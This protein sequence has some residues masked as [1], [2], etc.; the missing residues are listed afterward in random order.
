[1]DS[2]IGKKLDGRYEITELI[3]VGGMA[4][5]YKAQDVMENRPVAVKILKPEFSKDEEFLRRFRNESKAIAVLSHPNIVKIY[6]VGFTDEIQFIVMEYIDGITLKEFIEQQGV[7]KWKDALHFITQ[8]LRALQHAHDKG[9]VHRDIKPQNIM[10][11]SDGTIKVMDFGIARFSRIDGKTMSD[12]TIGSVHYI[13][14]EQAQGLMTDER[15]D[16]YS[17]GIMLYEMLTGRKPFDGD[18]AVAVAVKH[19]QEKAINPREIM[20]SIPEALEEIVIHAMEKKPAD[21]YQSAAEMI[22]D[23]DTFKLNQSV[24]FGYKEGSVPVAGNAAMFPMNNA[25][26]KP[27]PAPAPVVFDDYDDDD[28]YDDGYDDRFNNNYDDD[29][30]DDEYDEDD[31]DEYE[32]EEPKR[33]YVVPILLAVTVAV[34]ICAACIIGWTVIK[35]FVGQDGQGIHTST[36]T[37]PNFIGKN[38]VQVQQDWGQTLQF[39]LQNEYNNDY[40]E[41]T[42]FW[43]SQSAG[44]TVKEGF[45]ITLKVSKGKHMATVPDVTG[46]ESEVAQSTLK[47]ADFNIVL[48]RKYDENVAEGMVISTEPAAGAE[49]PVG[50]TVTVYVSNGPLDTQVKVPNLVGLTKE[51]AVA[52]LKEAKLVPIVEE[53]AH[54][55]DKGKVVDQSY[56]PD[57][58]VEKGTEVTIMVSTGE[59]DPEKLQIKVELPSGLH[60]SY[61][62]EVYRNGNVAY[63]QPISNGE[64]VGSFV[65]IEVEGKKTETLTVT[66]RNDESG[67]SVNYCVYNI[68]YEKKVATL[69]GSF[70]KDG[71]LA[72]TP[73]TT[74]ESS[75]SSQ[76]ETSSSEAETTAPPETTP[77][78]ETTTPEPDTTTETNTDTEAPVDP[79]S[80]AE[81]F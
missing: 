46:T 59:T 33:S 44:K 62:I 24:V 61:S 76:A 10:L 48:R 73:T 15:S 18:K 2:N 45:T 8:I 69:N 63:T 74:A 14:P 52:T 81:L 37:I 55:G 23:I 40:D 51:K 38:I 79:S 42:I 9:I 21:R 70:N 27:Q 72:I 53:V 36:V 7:L 22:R 41:G 60:G 31:E 56:D 78:P 4:D 80:M 49:Y 3:G 32:Y 67:K 71:L 54:D 43:Q 66:I 57:T 47:A 77:E 26:K 65:N 30:D 35:S 5:V 50:G 25:P 11:F 19:M 39:D 58:R 1:M 28:G 29:Y 68:D 75:S 34:V 16:I 17:V 6:D 12:K 20:P 64:A 13:S